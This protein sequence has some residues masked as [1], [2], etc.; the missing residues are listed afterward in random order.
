MFPVPNHIPA[1]PILTIEEFFAGH[2]PPDHSPET[3]LTLEVGDLRREL[4][5]SIIECGYLPA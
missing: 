3:E 2:C 5:R 1:D 4:E